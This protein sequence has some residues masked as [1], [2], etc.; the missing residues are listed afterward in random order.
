MKIIIIQKKIYPAI[1]CA[2]T[3]M[4]LEGTSQ[5]FA[6]YENKKTMTKNITSKNMYLLMPSSPMDRGIRAHGT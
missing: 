6:Q 2:G 5:F 4:M 1:C 3:G